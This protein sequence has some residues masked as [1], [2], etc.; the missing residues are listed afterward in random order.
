MV[1]GKSINSFNRIIAQSHGAQEMLFVV[2]REKISSDLQ[3][4]ISIHHLREEG[5]SILPAAV[6]KVSEVN[7][8]G[9][10]VKR[11]DLPL[12]K[13]SVPQYRTWKDWHGNDHSGV[14][15]RTMMVFPI[16][17]IRPQMEHLSLRIIGGKEYIVTRKVNVDEP[18]AAAIHLA[19]LMLELFQAFEIFDVERQRIAHVP[20]RQLQWELLP[21]GK[22]PWKSAE[23]IIKPCLDGLR[24][25]EK[26]VIEH[27]IREITH[28]EPD[29]L[30]T[31]RGGYQ[32]YFVLGFSTRGIYLL[33]SSNLDNAT[34][35]FGEDWEVLS[36]LTKGEIINGD[37]AHQRVIHDKAWRRKIRQML[38]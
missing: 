24:P 26:G 11:R 34:Y 12:V 38:A 37:R 7:A 27:R 17:F 1:T 4:R 20:A 25:S 8:R 13:K 28:F 32:G 9:K 15:I 5:D 14:Q 10:E 3:A 30:A 16:D 6:G 2:A 19:N 31:G 22:Y 36:T 18:P 23:K 29:F 35:V 33:E 21:P